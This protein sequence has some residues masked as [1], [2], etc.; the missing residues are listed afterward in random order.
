MEIL[1]KS[2][3]LYGLCIAGSIMCLVLSF[4]FTM[5]G[6][7]LFGEQVGYSMQGE[8]DGETKILYDNYFYSD[9]EDLQKQKYIDEG[10][11]LTEIPVKSTTVGWDV[12]AQIFLLFMMGVFVYNNQWDLGAKDTNLVKIGEKREDKFKGLKIG[13]ITSAPAF[14]FLTVLT[15]GKATFA[16]TFSIAY[17][18]MLNPHLHRAIYLLSGSSGKYFGEFGAVEIIALYG[19]LLFIPLLAYIAYLLGYKSIIVSEKLMFKKK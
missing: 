13:L 17:F 8:K 16:K 10:Y 1:K 6:A 14:I 2:F 12:L 19:M 3:K 9:G 4:T 7:N 11:E 18:S 15:I 5:I